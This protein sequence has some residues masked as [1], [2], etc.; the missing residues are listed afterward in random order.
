[1]DDLLSSI[2]SK[3]IF[4]FFVVGCVTNYI[5][6]MILEK[7]HQQKRNKWTA[8]NDCVSEGMSLISIGLSADKS[9]TWHKSEVNDL[10]QSLCT[11]VNNSELAKKTKFKVTITLEPF[12]KGLYI[13]NMSNNMYYSKHLLNIKLEEEEV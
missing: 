6:N 11:T 8:L 4:I 2:D 13:V 9:I 5:F 10:F 12:K 7:I 1:M 3:A